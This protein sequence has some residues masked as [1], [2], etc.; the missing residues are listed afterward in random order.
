[1]TLNL[2]QRKEINTEKDCS[3]GNIQYMGTKRKIS[4]ELIL[5]MHKRKPTA[6]YFI[7]L[8]GGGGAMSVR[9]LSLGYKVIYNEKKEDLF[10]FISFVFNQLK[11]KSKQSKYGILPEEYYEFVSKDEFLQSKKKEHKDIKDAFNL[12]Y[13]SFGSGCRQ[14]AFS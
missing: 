13:Y 5:E 11:D 12:L 4:Y 6:K 7:D 10:K 3:V 2:F 9:A 8:F 1:M 14:Y